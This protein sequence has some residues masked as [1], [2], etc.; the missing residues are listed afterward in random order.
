MK[1]V[2]LLYIAV[3]LPQPPEP[4]T[5]T[6]GGRQVPQQVT[7]STEVA[8]TCIANVGNFPPAPIT[9]FVSNS[10]TSPGQ[11]VTSK[12]AIADQR[13]KPWDLECSVRRISVLR[14]SLTCQELGNRVYVRCHVD[15]PNKTIARCENPQQDFCRWSPP[16]DIKGCDLEVMPTVSPDNGGSGA[17]PLSPGNNAGGEG[18]APIEYGDEDGQDGDSRASPAPP[19]NTKP[20]KTT[21]ETDWWTLTLSLVI[22]G[23]VLGTA[24]TVIL[25]SLLVRRAQRAKRPAGGAPDSLV[26]QGV[27]T[28]SLQL[29]DGA[30]TQYSGRTGGSGGSQYTASTEDTASV[31]T[32]DTESVITDDDT[33]SDMDSVR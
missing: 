7:D 26:Q 5:A 1:V 20:K 18:G 13:L 29:Q 19:K 15:H 14:L 6:S 12:A 9:W 21:A 17:T 11:S 16:V 10:K 4:M 3:V 24:L 27:Y 33:A 28:V 32:D 30:R 8:Y 31:G 23:V 25:V 22:V 2:I